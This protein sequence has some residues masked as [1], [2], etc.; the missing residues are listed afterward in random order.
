MPARPGHFVPA[1]GPPRVTT[2]SLSH[3]SPAVQRA[4]VVAGKTL[5]SAPAPDQSVYQP[6]ERLLAQADSR[7]KAELTTAIRNLEHAQAAAGQLLDRAA[8]MAA[9]AGAQLEAMAWAAW[10]KYM[11]A[12]DDTRNQILERARHGY[13]Q[14]ITYARNQYAAAL[15][16]AESTYQG[17]VNDA[18]RAQ[19]DAK[20]IVA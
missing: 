11:A 3:P 17:I 16:D 2:P 6:W 20:S 4:A 18:N 9:E 1:P 10:D 19:T 15:A 14:A 8:A 13:D 12:A 7:Y 5:A